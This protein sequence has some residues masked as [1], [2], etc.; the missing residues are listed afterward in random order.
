MG[1]NME[2]PQKIK[3]R[4]TKWSS[5]LTCRYISNGNEITIVKRYLYSHVHCR[6]IHNSKH[7]E[8][9]CVH[10]PM[11]A[12]EM[13]SIY[14]RVLFSY[15][16]KR[17]SCHLQQRGWIL[18]HYAKWNMLSGEKNTVWSHLYVYSKI[19]EL[20]ETK[21]NGGCQGLRSQGTREIVVKRHKLLVI[22][23]ISSGHLRHSMVTTVNNTVLYTWK[24]LW[25]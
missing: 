5:N 7:M 1:N 6:I 17:K 12:K 2:V 11:N 19:F 14:T 20:I 10:Q 4:T 24:L 16:N 15:K 3:N 22:R 25:E 21:Q 13:R 18:Q 8:T 9:T 23:W